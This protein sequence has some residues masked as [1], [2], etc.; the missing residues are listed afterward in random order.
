MYPSAVDETFL[1]TPTT[2]QT[3]DENP[4]GFDQVVSGESSKALKEE[5]A[6]RDKDNVTGAES[7]YNQLYALLGSKPTLQEVE[8]TEGFLDTVKAGLAKLGKWIKQF[9]VWL[10]EMIFGRGSKIKRQEADLS[11]LIKTGTLRGK[12]DYPSSIVPFC[13]IQSG[14]LGVLP[15]NLEWMKKEQKSLREFVNNTKEAIRTGI[16]TLDG[17]ERALKDVS[18]G[19]TRSIEAYGDAYALASGIW[20]KFKLRLRQSNPALHVYDAEGVIFGSY[21]CN[22]T[23]FG[24]NMRFSVSKYNRYTQRNTFSTTQST[25][26]SIFDENESLTVLL[27]TLHGETERALKRAIRFTENAA[28]SIPMEMRTEK[29]REYTRM[30]NTYI[31]SLSRLM[32]Y[33]TLDILKVQ[34]NINRTLMAAYR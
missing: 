30:A 15:S 23:C 3:Y 1:A 2:G 27:L 22:L 16:S 29:V 11:T 31:A 13:P 5:K 14:H 33:V 20:D 18:R 17:W 6:L 26:E 21:V 4:E 8:G 9:M 32:S 7:L 10:K 34:S 19:N 28:A 25:I 24:H 12:A